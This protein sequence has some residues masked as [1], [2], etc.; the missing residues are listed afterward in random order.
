MLHT[1]YTAILRKEKKILV[2]INSFLS[3]LCPQKQSQKLPI[4][5]LEIQSTISFE[6][7]AHIVFPVTFI[8]EKILPSFQTESCLGGQRQCLTRLCLPPDCLVHVRHIVS[9][10]SMKG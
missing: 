8:S 9:V 5:H 7:N 4:P 1:N 10:H 3:I 2:P 6:R